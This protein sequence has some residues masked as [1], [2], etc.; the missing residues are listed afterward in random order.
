MVKEIC[1]R[2]QKVVISRVPIAYLTFQR[3]K[4]HLRINVKTN[5]VK[6]KVTRDL[7]HEM[8]TTN[9]NG[10]YIDVLH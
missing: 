8:F 5:Y 10:N 9:F 7:K 4:I 6:N 3:L 1:Q 2:Y